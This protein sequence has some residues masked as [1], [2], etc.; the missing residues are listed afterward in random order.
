MPSFSGNIIDWRHYYN[1]FVKLIHIRTDLTDIQKLHY[2]HS[3]LSGE[4]LNVIKSIPITHE[5]YAVA[6]DVLK[7]R[8]DS[9]LIVSAHHIGNVLGVKS[10][11]PDSRVSISRFIDEITANINA[12]NSL[13][14]HVNTFEMILVQHLT[15]KLDTQ[16][17]R[18]WKEGL[19]DERLPDFNNFIKFL[20]NRR[21]VLQ[22]LDS[23]PS[24]IS[25]VNVSD[26][27][28]YRR[29]I[30]P[31]SINR[32]AFHARIVN[33][34][35]QLCKAKHRLIECPQFVA[36]TPLERK[37]ILIKNKL[38]LNCMRTGHD[39][40]HCPSKF[41]CRTCAKRHHTMIHIPSNNAS[42]SNNQCSLKL[43]TN[44]SIL[45]STAVC[46]TTDQAGRMHPVRILLD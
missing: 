36:I 27:S 29:A 8:Y 5:N 40:A 16:T 22:N 28:P 21:Q 26:K 19:S 6:I 20:N 35:C 18:L 41:S 23:V 12:L 44:R 43:Q 13:N 10:V 34:I 4:A 9:K 33:N 45:L 46:M 11:Q 30:K 32:T 31:I 37:N 17:C 38:C 7:N 1:I 39:F 24:S 3:S 15:Q 14:L 42:S 2:L 25:K